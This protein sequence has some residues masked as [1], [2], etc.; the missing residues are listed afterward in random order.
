MFD[1]GNLKFRKTI[2]CM[3]TWKSTK[4][5]ECWNLC[6]ALHPLYLD[7][8]WRWRFHMEENRAKYA[9][10]WFWI[11]GCVDFPMKITN[12]IFSE[13]I[14]V[15][16]LKIRIP[17]FK[18]TD[19]DETL[20][21][22]RSTHSKHILFSD[23][24]NLTDRFFIHMRWRFSIIIISL[25]IIFKNMRNR[26]LKCMK[27]AAMRMYQYSLIC[28]VTCRFSVEERFIEKCAIE[29]Y[30]SRFPYISDFN[31]ADKKL[32][33]IHDFSCMKNLNR[34]IWKTHPSEMFQYFVSVFSAPQWS[35]R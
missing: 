29:I 17:I 14:I 35:V 23:D 18:T 33:R 26:N 20:S 16:N 15:K 12:L 30:L 27:I 11:Y 5:L 21:G 34:D 3:K 7:E 13:I 24:R 28:F 31:F 19:F 22:L 32:F 6:T 1:I 9:V 4:I 2:F 10:R 8:S 25:I